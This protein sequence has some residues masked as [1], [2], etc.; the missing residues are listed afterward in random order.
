MAS[1][2]DYS[3]NRKL[4]VGTTAEV[5]VADG[6]A[7]IAGNVGIGTTSPDA[8]LDVHSSINISN[9]TSTVSEFADLNLRTYSS[10]WGYRQTKISSTLLDITT[11]NNRL[12]FTIAD[13][14]VTGSNIVAMSILSASGNVGIGTDSPS[15]QLTLGGNAVGSTQGLRINDPSNVAYGAHFSFSDTPNEVWIGGITNNT[16]NSA[17]GIHREATRAITID[18]NSNVG[19]GTTSPFTIGGTAKLSV[20]ASGPSTFGLS[21]SDAVYLRRYGVG[22]YQF[23]TTANSGNTGDLSLQSY[24]GNVGIG[25]TNPG[26]YSADAN[27]LVV[28][29]LS[30]NNGITILSTPSSGYGSIYFADA[31]TG[32]KV[33]SGFIRYQQNISD[34][35]FGTN[36]VEKMRLTL[37]GYLGIGTTDPGAKLEVSKGSSGFAGAYNSRTSAVFGNSATSGSTISIMSKNTG[38]SG[39]F[40]GDEDLET[41]GQLQYNHTDNSFKFLNNGGSERMRITVDGNVGIG[42]TSPS[43]KLEVEGLGVANTPLTLIKAFN[44]IPYSTGN[45]QGSATIEIGH[46]K[47][48]GYIEAGS[49]SETSSAAGYMA[50]GHRLQ[51]NITNEAMRIDPTGNVGI[52]TTSP[53]DLLQVGGTSAGNASISIASGGGSD[54]TLYFRRSTTYDAYIKVDSSEDLLIG[55]NSANLG[56]NLKIISNTG[57]VMRID[58]AGNVGIG[59]TSPIDELHVEGVIQSKK[60]LLPSTSGTAGWYKIGTLE[61]FVQGGSTAVIEIVGHVGYNATNNQD[62]SIKL[63]IKTSNGTGSGP[64]LQ[65]Y[66]SWYERTGGNGNSIELKWDNSATND[67]DLYMF[68]PAHS[69]RSY[70]SVTKGT[71]AWV[72]AG[73]SATDPGVNSASV[74]EATGLFNILDTNVGIGTTSPSS[75]LQVAGGVQMADDTDTASAD[76]VGTQRYRV[77]GNN[78]YVDMCMQTGAATYAWINIVQNNW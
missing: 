7:I 49:V 13:A 11:G 22:Q 72:N 36:E 6:N 61:S 63:F 4:Y 29:S 27:N 74:L 66:N 45:G 1:R 54:S 43:A 75:K 53:N 31:A 20:Y 48:H 78:S 46:N 55:Y 8:K 76:K 38:Y 2:I 12:D 26:S 33:Y 51:T 68:I 62:Y 47:M 71:G 10:N 56:D 37:E 67:Y 14:S 44:T 5:T 69:L 70:Y 64:Q 24:G 28:G 16:Y 34:M 17:I 58:S 65:K 77:S 15:Y 30:G 52:G 23:Q 25:N 59:T 60:Q 19:I 41:V 35:T 39:I 50:F 73:T 42:T 3:Q 9:P 57:E 32:N 40:F 18:V 21:S